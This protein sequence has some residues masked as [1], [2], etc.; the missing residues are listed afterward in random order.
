MRQLCI[1]TSRHASLLL[2]IVAGT[3]FSQKSAMVQLPNGFYSVLSERS[4]R[5]VA[6]MDSIPN[7]VLLYDGKYVDSTEMSS[8]LFIA[9]DTSSFVPLILS[10][11][12]TAQ[13]DG[14][15]RTLLGVTLAKTYIKRLED[16]TKAHLGGK[17]A[18]V[19]DGE[20]ITMHKIR[21]VIS[22]GKI[23]ITRCY[24][25]ACDVLLSKLTK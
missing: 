4:S 23:Q 8:P 6:G 20:I 18:I 5:A 17:V 3:A 12:P 25:N 14:S 21:S 22:E 7:I 1:R 13:K 16:F 2:L 24:D 9:I 11:S 19:L 15:G 10:G